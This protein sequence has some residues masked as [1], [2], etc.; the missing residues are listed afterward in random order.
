MNRIQISVDHVTI[1]LQPVAGL[2]ELLQS[3][4]TLLDRINEKLNTLGDKQP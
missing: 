2:D 1:Q 3:I 4:T